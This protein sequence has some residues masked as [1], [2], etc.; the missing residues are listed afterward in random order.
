[1]TD[2]RLSSPTWSSSVN[3]PTTGQSMSKTATRTLLVSLLNIWA[4]PRYFMAAFRWSDMYNAR[5]V[6]QKEGLLTYRHNNLRLRGAV[7][8]DVVR[9]VMHVGHELT[10]QALLRTVC[11]TMA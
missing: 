9:M 10:A 11:G 1:M 8:G 2:T 3:P 6:S 7:T 5:Q 4:T